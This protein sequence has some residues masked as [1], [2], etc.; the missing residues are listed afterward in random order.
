MKQKTW[1]Q[2]IVHR[3]NGETLPDCYLFE[4]GEGNRVHTITLAKVRS[5]GLAYQVMETFQNI[6]PQ[7][8]YTLH[9]V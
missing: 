9:L 1:Y 3:I 4:D 5:K 8:M 7:D 6:Y 2:I